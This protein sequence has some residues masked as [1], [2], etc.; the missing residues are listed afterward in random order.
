MNIRL[1]QLSITL[2]IVTL[3]VSLLPAGSSASDEMPVPNAKEN[4]LDKIYSDESHCLTLADMRGDQDMPISC[5]CR[6]AIVEALYVNFTYLLSSKDLNLTGIFIVLAGN[7]SQKCGQALNAFDIASRK[8]W[9]WDGP[10][11]IRTYPP[12]DV[13]KRIKPS[14]DGVRSV[15]FT[16]QLIYRDDKGRVIRTENYSSYYPDLR[17][18]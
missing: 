13:V 9:K 6:D 15:P 14:K 4:A 16:I 18:K 7:V 3:A 11:V 10:E 2:L 17:F 1:S 5:Y 8:N 12:D